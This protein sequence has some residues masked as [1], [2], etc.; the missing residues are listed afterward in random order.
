MKLWKLLPK[1]QTTEVLRKAWTVTVK[2]LSLWH[3]ANTEN[4][5][6]LDHKSAHVWVWSESKTTQLK[7]SQDQQ[8]I[9]SVAPEE[10]QRGRESSCFG[11]NAALKQVSF[12]EQRNCLL[13]FDPT[14]NSMC[15]LCKYSAKHIPNLKFSGFNIFYFKSLGWNQN[16]ISGVL[17]I[18][19]IA[20]VFLKSGAFVNCISQTFAHLEVDINLCQKNWS[21]K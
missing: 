15:F 16:Y 4:E 18:G 1:S 17:D 13:L 21:I 3:F 5:C 10:I 14:V 11:Q 8:R 19:S 12:S 2:K 6:R 7:K 9:S 20:T